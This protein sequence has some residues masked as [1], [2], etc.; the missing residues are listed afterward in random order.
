MKTLRHKII[1]YDDVCP[2]CKTYTKG[3]VSL[4][5]LL[6]EHR[7]GFSEAPPALLGRIDLDRAR[8]EIPL[9]D[10]ESGETL[11]GKDALFYILGEALPLLKPLFR[12]PLFRAA[13]FGLYQ[14]ITYNRR[15]IAGSRKPERGF[16]CAPDFNVFYR[17]LYTSIMF[18][19]AGLLCYNTAPAPGIVSQQ[20]LAAM[21]S[22]GVLRGLF[23]PN[24]RRRIAY[25]GHF[26]TLAFIVAL[27]ARILGWNVWT[28]ALLP[29]FAAYLLAKRTAL[30]DD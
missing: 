30:L 24:L 29:V 11:Y 16:D 2:L 22:L 10:I 6:P 7:I 9:H 20:I 14:L 21:A 18:G 3:F 4:G 27:F 13:V 17:V 8:H 5:W 15:V 1:L 25:F 12:F 28:C 19:F 26:A 23:F